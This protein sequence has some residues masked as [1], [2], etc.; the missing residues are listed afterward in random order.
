MKKNN[1]LVQIDSNIKAN[2]PQLY[3][4]D[5][6]TT[7]QEFITA[8]REIWD[9]VNENPNLRIRFQLDNIGEVK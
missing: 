7:K 5:V 4:K 3:G 1:I 9:A 6:I 8:C 2:G